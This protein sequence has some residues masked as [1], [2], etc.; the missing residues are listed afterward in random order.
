MKCTFVTRAT[1]SD[2]NLWQILFLPII[3]YLYIDNSGTNSLDYQSL[4]TTSNL[5]KP[6]DIVDKFSQQDIIL[7]APQT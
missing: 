6:I 2:S 5:A 3:R 1:K 4:L 7:S